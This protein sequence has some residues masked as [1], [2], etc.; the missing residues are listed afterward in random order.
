MPDA[1]FAEPRLAAI[2]DALE[3]ERPDLEAYA[4]LVDALGARS[5]LDIGC[6]T[7]T[8]ACLL[9]SRGLEVTGADPAAASLDV[10]RRKPGADWARWPGTREFSF[11]ERSVVSRPEPRRLLRP[12]SSGRGSLSLRLEAGIAR[13]RVG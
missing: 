3:G 4:A 7:G 6:G 2:Y 11:T 1:L 5:V 9:A 13:Q 8:F 10:A 12:S